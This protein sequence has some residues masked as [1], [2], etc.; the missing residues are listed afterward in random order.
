LPIGARVVS[1]I[2]DMSNIWP[3]DRT[4]SVNGKNIYYWTITEKQKK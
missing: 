3:A 2:W 4:V 1:Y